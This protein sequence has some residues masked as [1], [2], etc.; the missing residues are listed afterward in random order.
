MKRNDLGKPNFKKDRADESQEMKESLG[1]MNVKKVNFG[2]TRLS[3]GDSIF[4]EERNS[5]ARTCDG[6]SWRANGQRGKNRGLVE[7]MGRDLGRS[8][9]IEK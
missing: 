7:E 4:K 2:E 1:G 5:G 8:N 6:G 9:V 3:L